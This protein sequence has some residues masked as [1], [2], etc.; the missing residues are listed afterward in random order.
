MV[1]LREF[2][3]KDIQDDY[4]TD[5]GL[6]TYRFDIFKGAA[7]SSGVQW[8]RSIGTARLTEG[9]RTHILQL[10][11][12][13]GDTFYLLPE[14]PDG[15]SRADFAILTREQSTIPGRRFFWNKV[16][17]AVSLPPPNSAVLHLCWDFFGASDIYMSMTPSSDAGEN[18]AEV[19]S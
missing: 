15:S 11:C 3:T 18:A 5:R 12:L 7:S 8:V 6:K 17:E 4:P 9:Y 2:F 10:K 19:A 13:L 1:Q 16:G 14:R